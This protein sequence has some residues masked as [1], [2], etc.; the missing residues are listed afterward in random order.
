MTRDELF[1]WCRQETR[2]RTR[3]EHRRTRDEQEYDLD[4]QLK[5]AEAFS[6]EYA[7]SAEL[8]RLR[9]DAD[10]DRTGPDSQTIRGVICGGCCGWKTPPTSEELYEAMRSPNPSER[11]RAVATVLIHEADFEDLMNAH[12]ERAFTW[13]QLVRAMHLRDY[14]PPRRA[15]QVNA[16]ADPDLEERAPW[17][18]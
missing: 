2:R 4:I 17:K 13:R 5:P 12:I 9:P 10:P 3:D 16:F 1:A 18:R 14:V 6:D 11:Q 15:R 7:P 8:A